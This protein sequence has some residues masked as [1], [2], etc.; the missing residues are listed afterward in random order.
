MVCGDPL[1]LRH[2]NRKLKTS[3][4]SVVE[5]RPSP[6][7]G[8]GVFAT[9]SIS[10]G[11][12]ITLYPCDVSLAIDN[13]A[14]SN[15]H[16]YDRNLSTDQ[17]H[18]LLNGDYRQTLQGNTLILAGDPQLTDDPWFIGHLINDSCKIDPTTAS[19]KVLDVALVYSICSLAKSNAF[20]YEVYSEH[21]D[22]YALAIVAMR[23]IA[24]GEEVLC[25]YNHQFWLTEDKLKQARA[26]KSDEYMMQWTTRV[27]NRGIDAWS[28]M[29]A[30]LPNEAFDFDRSLARKK[31]FDARFKYYKSQTEVG[32]VIELTSILQQLQ[33]LAG[34]IGLDLYNRR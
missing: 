28:A 29:K 32:A 33:S 24:E 30:A 13:D 12:V 27:Q 25:S 15:E 1:V 14:K 11:Q 34:K 9:R 18:E 19:D 6:I 26:S 8:R 23:D 5:V 21:D 7:H 3:T 10:K 31:Q 17:I 16:A 2:M 4:A 20:Y 22:L